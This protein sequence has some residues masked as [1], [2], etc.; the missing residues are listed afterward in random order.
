MTKGKLFEL[1]CAGSTA[2]NDVSPKVKAALKHAKAAGAQISKARHSSKMKIETPKDIKGEVKTD[3]CYGPDTV[4]AKLDGDVQLSSAE[5]TRSAQMFESVLK[6]F[7]DEGR[8]GTIE[9]H[10]VQDIILALD[11]MPTKMVTPD[12]LD[13]A[14]KNKP[15]IV[16]EMLSEGKIRDEYNW[17]VWEA[18]NKKSLVAAIKSYLTDHPEFKHRLIEEALTGRYTFGKNSLATANFILTPY[19]YLPI[20]DDY[21]QKVAKD[22]KIGIRAKSRKGI[23]SGTMRIDYKVTDP[24]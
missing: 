8:V 2:T 21:V 14:K 5:G 22:V 23:S 13:K 1:G 15:T 17:K 3:L 7:V 6:S 11:A 12:N 4:S 20:D 24:A 18:Q 10:R 19:Y 9:Y 16:K